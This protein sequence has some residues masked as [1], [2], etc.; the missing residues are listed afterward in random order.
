MP[1]IYVNYSGLDRMGR[2][3]TLVASKVEVLR[4]EF[5][6]TIRQLDWDVRFESDINN[7]SKQ[8]ARKLERYSEVLGKYQRFIEDAKSAYVKLDEDAFL[9]SEKNSSTTL[10]EYGWK[11]V[12]ESFGNIG[13]LI[14]GIHGVCEA[15]W[16]KKAKG[17]LN[18]GTSIAEIAKDYKRYT[19]IGRAIGSKNAMAA[20][21][22][23]QLGIK[24][25]GYASTARSV[26]ARFHNNLFNK[27]SPYN[28]KDSFGSLTGKK[29]VGTAV[30]KWA[31]V[32][33]TGITNAYSNLEEQ[34]ESNGQ[35]STGRVVAETISET[36][37]DTVV[38]CAGTAVVG[39]AI[40][41][42]TGVVAAPVVVAVVTGVAI[43]GV[44]ALVKKNTGKTATEF[45]SDGIL[46]GLSFKGKEIANGAKAVAKWFPKLSFT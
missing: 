43:A 38:T 33:L 11:E 16:H 8:I 45:V 27:T 28:L 14:G 46:D 30:A 1:R 23:K 19:K 20:F 39:A 31:G 37:I 25:T 3:C 34:K 44:N 35:M 4:Q 6:R 5:Q 2:Q 17:V 10:F 18:I 29:G 12:A 15:T 24:A 9:I 22:T 36:A 32:A 41:A 21:W 40:T 7:T 42:V 13:G 26:Q